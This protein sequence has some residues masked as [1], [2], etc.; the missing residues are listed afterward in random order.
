MRWDGKLW[1][2]EMVDEMVDCEMRWYVVRWDI[3]FIINHVIS[4]LPSHQSLFESWVVLKW[5][6]HPYKQPPIYEVKSTM[7]SK[8]DNN[9]SH[10]LP[11]HNLSHN[12]PSLTKLATSSS[13]FKDCKIR[14]KILKTCY[15]MKWDDMVSCETR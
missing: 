11:S 3:K 6:F 8:N 12:L 5:L 7:S 4:H 1:D 13:Q 14:T 2:D 9:L 15:L 10:N